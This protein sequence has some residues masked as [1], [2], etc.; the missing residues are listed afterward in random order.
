MKLKA[1]N[2]SFW[3]NMLFY[4]IRT[5][6]NKNNYQSNNVL[7]IYKMYALVCD[8][9]PAKKSISVECSVTIY[10]TTVDAEYCCRA[11]VKIYQAVA[12]T[13]HKGVYTNNCKI[14]TLKYTTSET[15]DPLKVGDQVF[16]IDKGE[17]YE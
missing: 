3:L 8:A 6:L 2:K 17:A 4:I 15:K 16:L 12:T 13:F 1:R 9:K 5:F 10:V 7:L 14:C 11:G